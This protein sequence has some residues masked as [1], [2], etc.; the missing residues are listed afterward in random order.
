MPVIQ[1]RDSLPKKAVCQVFEDTNTS[2]CDLNFFDLMTASYCAD[3]FSLRDDWKCREI[4]LKSLKVLRNLRNT[5]FIQAVTLVAGY[6]RRQKAL[7]ANVSWEK[8]PAINC[9]RLE[10]LKLLPEEYQTWADPV[11]KGFEEAARFLHSQKIFDAN[12]IAYPIQLVALTAVLTVLGKQSESEQVRS[13][14]KH[15]LWS[16]M[17]GEIYTRGHELRAG[18]DL[19]EVP[20]WLLDGSF[21]TTISSA[22]FSVQRLLS[23]RKRYGAVYQGLSALLRLSGAIDWITGEEINDVLYFQQQVESHHIFPVSWCRKQGIDPKYYN[24]LVNR[25]PLS[26][27]TNKKI[28]SKAPSVYLKLFEKS[29]TS[30]QRLHEMLRSHA[31]D[32][33]KLRLDD[34]EGFFASRT[35]ALMELISKAMGKR[36][37]SEPFEP[38]HQDYKNGNGNGLLPSG[39]LNP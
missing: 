7:S 31:I 3:S 21:P 22:N 5:D 11:M 34:F 29:G 20:L 28:G 32:P 30:P 38:S 15:W 6:A 14:L 23:A 36:L 8:L 17:F 13:S 16:G 39:I 37:T 4:R 1:L 9:R 25:T 10:V 19:Q 27:N 24:C 35:K 18:Q 12:D 2:G 26:A 33:E